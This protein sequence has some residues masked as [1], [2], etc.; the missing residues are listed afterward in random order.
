MGDEKHW[1]RVHARETL[2]LALPLMGAQ[3]LQLSMVFVDSVMVGHLGAEPLAA[4]AIASTFY[5]ILYLSA[6]GVL[7]AVGPLVGQAHGGG[8]GEGVGVIFKQG[9]IIAVAFGVAGGLSCVV[10]E[11]V[12]RLLGQREELVVIAGRYLDV[13]GLALLPQL[14]FVCLRQLTEGTSDTRPSFWAAALGAAVNAIAD[15]AL[16]FGK[17]GCPA[18]GVVGAALATVLVSWVMALS[19]GA[20]V[21]LGPRQRTRRAFARP[22]RYDGRIAAELFRVGIPASG[23]IV[24]EVA[25]FGATTFLM[26]TLGS[27]ELAAHQIALNAASFTFMIP[28]GLSFAVAI[29]VSQARG[30]KD[31]LAVKRAGRSGL[32]LTAAIQCVAATAFLVFPEMITRLYTPDATLQSSATTLLRI[33]GVFQCFDGLQCVGLG[34]L[35]GLKETRAPFLTALVSYWLIGL[36]VGGLLTFALDRGPVGLWH[37]MVVALGVA[38]FLHLRRFERTASAAVVPVLPVETRASA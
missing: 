16:V 33:A 19:L 29:R 21:W 7:S 11:P 38:A 36:P 18:L 26:G 23:A 15:Y 30:R 25:Y 6:L 1:F 8:E 14:V 31:A 3:L 10:S 28:L 5:T 12:L 9:A 13:A 24:G 2:V 27:H 4:M 37:G 22:W 35:R 34:A 20:Y 17:W 32:A